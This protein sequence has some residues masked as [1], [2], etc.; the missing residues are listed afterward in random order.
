[1][2][3]DPPLD[4]AQCLRFQ[5]SM[6]AA[7][8]TCWVCGAGPPSLGPAAPPHTPSLPCY[9]LLVPAGFAYSYIPKKGRLM[10]LTSAPFQG[11]P[12]PTRLPTPDRDKAVPNAARSDDPSLRFETSKKR[13]NGII[14]NV[15]P[16]LVKPHP[17]T[18]LQLQT[19]RVHDEAM[20]PPVGAW[21]TYVD[22][23]P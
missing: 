11:S 5:T 18:R 12:N 1:L 15:R 9:I 8:I 19:R 13:A 10:L 3:R 7:T 21:V 22:A 16:A 17:Q 14:R 6:I 2:Y 23:S 20:T 4:Y